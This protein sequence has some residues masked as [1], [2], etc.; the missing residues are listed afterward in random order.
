M[1][2]ITR[3][4]K[5]RYLDACQ[6][7]RKG[8]LTVRT[9][10][11]DVHHF[12]GGEGPQAE[13]IVR[14]WRVITAVATRGDVGF[15]EAYVDGLWDTNSIE[16][17]MQLVIVN[18]AE[19]KLQRPDRLNALKFL[20]IDRILRINTQKGSKRNIRTHYDVGN[21]FYQLWL[22]RSMTYSSALFDG[23]DE[24]LEM[25]Q[26]RK[27]RRI[28]DVLA[29]GES[30]LDI[31]CGWGS[32]A[33]CA[34][35]C[36]RRVTGLT[37][38][39]S[40]KGY[41]DA[42]L[43][44]RADIRLLDY[45]NSS[46]R[47]DNVVS[48]EMIEAV[49]ERYWPAYFSTVKQRLSDAGRAVI[50]VITVPDDRFERYKRKSDFFRQHTFPGGMLLSHAKIRSE[51]ERAGLKI[52][53]VFSFGEDYARTC[54]MWLDRLNDKRPEIKSLGYRERF[55]RSWQYYLATSAAAFATKNTDVSQVRFVHA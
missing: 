10:E 16:N 28:L 4:L 17:A 43:D 25:A 38:S 35:Q 8:S 31:G 32:F 2:F 52:D 26:R 55:L 49:G 53:E 41:A 1:L 39:P 36:G 5:T 50:Q 15:G 13:I 46:G 3:R 42:R 11:G 45:R 51:A 14:D 23:A 27:H 34:A 18:A 21:E 33:E 54:R 12:S 48:I 6:R 30:I 24:D 44:G 9:P 40:Q 29:D 22:D 20:C 7:I 19:M 47:Y 37:I